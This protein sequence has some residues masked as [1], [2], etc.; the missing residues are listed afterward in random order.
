MKSL[1]FGSISHNNFERTT[2]AF[3]LHETKSV[4][5]VES[6]HISSTLTVWEISNRKTTVENF[7]PS[8]M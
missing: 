7:I 8:S 3:A 5:P 4:L 2:F 6:R 1:A